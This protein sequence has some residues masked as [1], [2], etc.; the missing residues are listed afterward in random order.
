MDWQRWASPGCD[1]AN[2]AELAI[3]GLGFARGE[4]LEWGGRC[5][6][7]VGIRRGDWLTESS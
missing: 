5:R 6:G 7:D 4:R 1:V 2:G 3:A